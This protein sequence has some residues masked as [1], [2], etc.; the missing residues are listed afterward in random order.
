MYHVVR[1]L[2]SSVL[3]VVLTLILSAHLALLE[4]LLLSQEGVVAINQVGEWLQLNV[5]LD[6]EV[7]ADTDSS[8]PVTITAT[9]L[10]A[11]R[12]DGDRIYL[13]PA[14]T[15]AAAA[16]AAAAAPTV[17]TTAAYNAE[18]LVVIDDLPPAAGT[19]AG[20]AVSEGSSGDGSAAAAATDSISDS[21]S[22]GSQPVNPA[23]AVVDP[24]ASAGSDAESEG[25]PGAAQPEVELRGDTARLHAAVHA[26]ACAAAKAY[27]RQALADLLVAWPKRAVVPTAAASGASRWGAVGAA[28]VAEEGF[29]VQAFGGVQPFL[30]LVRQTH[31]AATAEQATAT[32][33]LALKILED[34]AL[35]A[36]S[37]NVF[38]VLGVVRSAAVLVVHCSISLAASNA[39][40]Q[41][42]AA[43]TVSHSVSN[44][45]LYAAR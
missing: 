39:Y 15:A 38:D 11:R 17:A 29:N 40:Y 24:S 6:D 45:L 31:S 28:V 7:L 18:T 4:C 34:K 35:E 22:S 3:T 32:D 12:R 2:C 13:T 1:S 26:T 36:V 25:P 8:T 16:A 19:A 20:E 27:A 10:W 33:K 42:T 5:D 37:S 14:G 41:S 21:T 30:R 44:A 43:F 9:C 23:Y